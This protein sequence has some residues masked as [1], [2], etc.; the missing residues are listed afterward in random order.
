M[1][2][3]QVVVPHLLGMRVYSSWSFEPLINSIFR[4]GWRRIWRS[5]GGAEVWIPIFRRYTLGLRQSLGSLFRK[6]GNLFLDHGGL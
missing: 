3:L 5:S 6:H 4:S 2:I 1:L